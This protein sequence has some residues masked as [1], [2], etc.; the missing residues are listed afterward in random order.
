MN[1][2]CCT[3]WGHQDCSLSIATQVQ[4][5]LQQLI[6]QECVQTF[7]IGHQGNFDSLVYTVLQELASVYSK[8]SFYVVLAHWPIHE[9][10]LDLSNCIYITDIDEV[11]LHQA[12]FRR[13]HYMLEWSDIVIT[14]A[15]NHDSDTAFWAAQARQMGKRV[16]EIQL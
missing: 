5:I 10:N 15:A 4:E 1:Y 14:Y 11:D 6:E 12:T 2:P 8:L 9:A 16:I 3:F 13:N 7:Y